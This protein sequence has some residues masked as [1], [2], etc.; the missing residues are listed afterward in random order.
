MDPPDELF[1]L[2]G[3]SLAEM[4]DSF[5]KSGGGDVTKALDQTPHTGRVES[6]V[7]VDEGWGFTV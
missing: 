2:K 1:N 3:S 4:M 6:R 5:W 7:V